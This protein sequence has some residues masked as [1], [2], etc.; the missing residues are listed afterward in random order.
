[1]K[2]MSQP[3]RQLLLSIAPVEF[4]GQLVARSDLGLE[5]WK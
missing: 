4:I 1:M 2:T 3:T 5:D